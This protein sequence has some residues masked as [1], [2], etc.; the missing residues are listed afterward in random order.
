MASVSNKSENKE[1]KAKKSRNGQSL[2]RADSSFCSFRLMIETL[3]NGSKK[4]QVQL[5]AKREP[6]RQDKNK[7]KKTGWTLFSVVL[8]LLTRTTRYRSQRKSNWYRYVT[9]SLSFV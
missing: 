7:I 8:L 4:G 5:A 3:E 1:N 6:S 9:P 2:G